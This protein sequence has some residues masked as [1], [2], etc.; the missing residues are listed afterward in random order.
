[1]VETI[2]MDAIRAMSIE[3]RLTLIE[4]IWET[5]DA[6]TP[7]DEVPLS[8]E[9]R[10]ILDRRLDDMERNPGRGRPWDGIWEHVRGGDD[11]T[12]R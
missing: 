3:Q 9:Q 12:D 5:I 11:A 6:E 8:Y 2:S 4:K 1:M 10:E 7:P